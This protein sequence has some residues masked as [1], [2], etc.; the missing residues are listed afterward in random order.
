MDI[1]LDSN[2]MVY[3]H[4]STF[5]SFSFKCY[6]SLSLSLCFSRHYSLLPRQYTSLT[7]HILIF[8]LELLADKQNKTSPNIY[9]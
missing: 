2:S 7:E 4:T 5:T 1:D 3:G 8:V 6:L 9:V